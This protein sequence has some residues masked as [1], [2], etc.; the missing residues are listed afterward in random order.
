MLKPIVVPLVFALIAA[1]VTAGYR[2]ASAAAT[3]SVSQIAGLNNAM[4]AY[5]SSA[6]RQK[7]TGRSVASPNRPIV[8]SDGA[9]T[10][11]GTLPGF[12][13]SQGYD[14]NDAGQVVGWASN[15]I[16]FGYDPADR[17]FVYSGGTM[18][19]LPVLPGNGFTH[20]YS[21]NNG[22]TIVGSSGGNHPYKFNVGDA[23]LTPLAFPAGG[24][25]AGRAMS[26]NTA[27]DIVGF[28]FASATTP[29]RRPILWDGGV[30][31][32]ALPLPPGANTAHPSIIND[33]GVIAGTAFFGTAVRGYYYDA[34]GTPVDMGSL[35]PSFTSTEVFD[36]NSSYD[37]VG[38]AWSS[39]TFTLSPFLYRDG[40]MVDLNTLLPAGSGWVLTRAI[41]I[42]DLGEIIGTGTFNGSP[43]GFKLTPIPEPAV[44]VSLVV[45]TTAALLRRRHGRGR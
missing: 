42:N 20:A 6:N 45:I 2:P 36:I 30:T 16:G 34:A 24:A 25:G 43:S 7:I 23:A 37:A 17:A 18:T 11:L 33:A 21:I 31:P 12:A 14:V 38:S 39:T 13:H 9:A 32:I 28:E 19:Q 29:T 44:L 3:H 27:G 5:G 10:T 22:G 4:Y 35:G 1:G 40:T 15:A 8:Y 26:I 41:S